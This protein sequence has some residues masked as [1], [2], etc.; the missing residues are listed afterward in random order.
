MRQGNPVVSLLFDC[1]VAIDWMVG[2]EGIQLRRS[3]EVWG[4]ANDSKGVCSLGL[5][6]TRK[7]IP[8]APRKPR[9]KCSA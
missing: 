4:Y 2:V 7:S 1:P 3:L 8:Q 9:E 6:V 5:E